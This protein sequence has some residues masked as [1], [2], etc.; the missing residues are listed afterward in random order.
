MSNIS[1]AFQSFRCPN[2]DNFFRKLFHLEQHLTTCNERVKNVSPKNV[3]QTQ[4]TLFDKLDFFVIEYIIEQTIFEDLTI[5]DFES[6]FVQEESFKGADT[7]N[8]IGKQIPISV[9]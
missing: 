8:W 9:S 3:Y 2:C 4:E 5:I 7:T 1:A 6:V